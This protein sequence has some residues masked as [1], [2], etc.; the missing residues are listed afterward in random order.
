MAAARKKDSSK[1]TSMEEFE[2]KYQEI[3]SLY[4]YAEELVST[5]ESDFASDP[6]KQLE[7]VEPLIN[8]MSDA[9]DELAKQLLFIAET[10]KYKTPSKVNKVHIEASLRKIFA[11]LND[12]H[13][14]VRDNT[15]KAHGAIMNIA[16]VIVKKI[17][18]QVEQIVMIFLEFVHISLHNIMDKP[19]L[20]ALKVRDPRIVALMMHQQA[21]QQ[22]Q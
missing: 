19:A 16:D 3:T 15:K 2:A 11:A 8:D 20:E 10:R 1:T 22:Q 14:R 4:D 7:I 18:Q 9:T 17:T 5:V 21:M 6:A 12:Y 13:A